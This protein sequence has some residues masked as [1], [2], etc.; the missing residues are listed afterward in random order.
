MR[1]LSPAALSRWSRQRG[2]LNISRSYT[3][4]RPVRGI[5]YICIINPRRAPN[6][7][8]FLCFCI[9]F[10]NS[11]I[12]QKLTVIEPVP[13]K[14]CLIIAC[15]SRC[16]ATAVC[17]TIASCKSLMWMGI[18]EAS[19]EFWTGISLL[20][21]DRRSL[22]PFFLTGSGRSYLSKS[23]S[24]RSVNYLTERFPVLPPPAQPPVHVASNRDSW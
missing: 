18:L 4:V 7:R 3:P 10:L 8:H 5:L 22:A 23:I 9:Q 15:C 17:I 13:S 16:L 20:L 24:R 14:C 2:I 6:I 11:S 19:L 12:A 21:R 1:L